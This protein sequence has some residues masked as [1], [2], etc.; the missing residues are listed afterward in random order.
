ML[1]RWWKRLA[2]RYADAAEAVDG[3][4]AEA[5][6]NSP[7]TPHMACIRM[8]LCNVLGSQMGNCITA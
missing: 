5:A 1:M 2:E 4:A 6:E 3:G 8:T 7:Y